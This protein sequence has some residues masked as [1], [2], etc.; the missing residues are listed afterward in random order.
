MQAVQTV[1]TMAYFVSPCLGFEFTGNKAVLLGVYYA[2]I[3]L[4]N[5]KPAI[6]INFQLCITLKNYRVK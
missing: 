3:K 1:G 5:N 2:A 6:I 4:P